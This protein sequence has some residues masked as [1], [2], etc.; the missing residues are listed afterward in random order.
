MEKE[1]LK[2]RKKSYGIAFIILL[3]CNGLRSNLAGQY[4]STLRP[5]FSDQ[6]YVMKEMYFLIAVNIAITIGIVF[7]AIMWFILRYK[8]KKL[9]DSV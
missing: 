1:I 3:I 9:N 4:T 5:G 2:K 6:V 8:I 7:T